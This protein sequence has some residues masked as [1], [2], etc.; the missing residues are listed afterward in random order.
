[1]CPR[2]GGEVRKRLYEEGL[3]AGAVTA[4]T[5][6][7]M[8]EER[9]NFV[10][11][12]GLLQLYYCRYAFTGNRSDGGVGR[13]HERRVVFPVL[14]GWRYSRYISA[15]LHRCRTPSS[16]FRLTGCPA[17]R[18]RRRRRRITYRVFLTYTH[19]HVYIAAITTG[20]FFTQHTLLL[21]DESSAIYRVYWFNSLYYGL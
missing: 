11:N 20:I 12:K 1:M 6:T 16:Y 4:A 13:A 15:V 5:A 9:G 21:H 3:T 14:D 10:G 17:G 7:A 2:G 19:T 18:R 8:E